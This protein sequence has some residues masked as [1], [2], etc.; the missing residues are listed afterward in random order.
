[1][2]DL[3]FEVEGKTIRVD[4]GYALFSVVSHCLKKFHEAQ[5]VQ[6]ALIRGSYI[7]NGELRLLPGSCLTLRLSSEKISFYKKKLSGKIFNLDGHRISI[8]GAACQRLIPAAVLYAHLVTTRNGLDQKRFEAEIRRQL[9]RQA[10][11]GRITVGRRRIFSIH[12]KKVVGYSLLVSELTAEESI[13]IQEEGVGGR[14]KMGCGFFQ[15]WNR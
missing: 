15:P 7:G 12:D 3:N 9:D 14:R 11:Q 8:G 10:C 6:L 4:H 5:D 2:I 1:M 13:I